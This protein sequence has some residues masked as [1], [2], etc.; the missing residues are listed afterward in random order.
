MKTTPHPRRCRAAP[1]P[2]SGRGEGEGSSRAV[3][4]TFS[5]P[6]ESRNPGRRHP[7]P[8]GCG[9]RA[10]HQSGDRRRG[11]IG[12]EMAEAL[13]MRGLNVS[14]VERSSAVMNTLDTDMGDIV[15][16]AL[17]DVGVAL[18]LD[19]SVQGFE[20]RRRP[21]HRRQYGPAYA[22]G[23]TGNSGHWHPTQQRASE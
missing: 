3:A 18:Y 8:A 23:G 14:L 11:Y 19:E 5:S 6:G 4:L 20:T 15:S 17:R 2:R 9:A 16:Q 1:S 7:R 13:V 12:L 21:A 10:S 22:A